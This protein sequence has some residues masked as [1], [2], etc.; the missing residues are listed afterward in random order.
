MLNVG[1]YIYN[2]PKDEPNWEIARDK[3]ADEKKLH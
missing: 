3:T 1:G 2:Y